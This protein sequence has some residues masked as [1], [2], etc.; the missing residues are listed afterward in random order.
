MVDRARGSGGFTL[1][2]LLVVFALMGLLL[3]LVSPRVQSAL[4][5]FE[6]RT[7][8]R[9]LAAALR[10]TRSQALRTGEPAA[11]TVDLARGRYDIAGGGARTLPTN[12]E[13]EVTASRRDV[14]AGRRR[15]RFRFYPDGTALGGAVALRRGD[16]AYVVDIDWLTGRVRI[17]DQ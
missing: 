4:P 17:A 6:L 7:A 11:L 13:V 14:D 9:E 12:L 1:I 15:A 5:G 10:E 8:T 3:A 16:D 2:E